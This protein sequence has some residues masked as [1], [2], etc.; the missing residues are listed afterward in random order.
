MSEAVLTQN[1]ADVEQ[2]THAGKVEKRRGDKRFILVRGQLS[3]YPGREFAWEE[4]KAFG[5]FDI[6]TGAMELVYAA[7]ALANLGR[8]RLVEYQTHHPDQFLEMQHEALM[9]SRK[10]RDELEAARLRK[11]KDDTTQ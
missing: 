10:E 8:E 3:S 6:L 11:R 2:V 1:A 4:L 7:N 9:R 5:V